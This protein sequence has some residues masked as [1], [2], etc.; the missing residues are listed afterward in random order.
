MTQQQ[1]EELHVIVKAMEKEESSG[2]KRDRERDVAILALPDKKARV[3]EWSV[4][5]LRR[6]TKYLAGVAEWF[7]GLS[8]AVSNVDVERGHACVPSQLASKHVSQFSMKHQFDLR[9]ICHGIAHR[10]AADMQIMQ[11]F[12][13]QMDLAVPFLSG[14]DREMEVPPEQHDREACVEICQA[15]TIDAISDGHWFARPDETDKN[16]NRDDA[17]SA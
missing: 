6:E 16:V 11:M 14:L 13:K 8:Q 9:R 10:W 15:A 2:V 17:E 5:C 7:R 12:A 1:Q 3:T 4:D